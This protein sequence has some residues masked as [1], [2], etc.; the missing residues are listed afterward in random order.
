M[1][2]SLLLFVFLFP[3]LVFAQ[4]NYNLENFSKRPLW[5]GMMQDT[6]A[7]YFIAQIAY[8]TFWKDKEKPFNEDETIGESGTQSLNENGNIFQR[9]KARRELKQKREMHDL[10]FLDCKRFEH[11]LFVNKPYVQEDGSILSPNAQYQ[12]YLNQRQSNK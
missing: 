11:W 1:K 7:N 10:Y 12:I 2:K 9:I 6:N 4:S 3:I 8:E 5:I